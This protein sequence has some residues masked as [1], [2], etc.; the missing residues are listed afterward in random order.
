MAPS[1]ERD[2]GEKREK[3][4]REGGIRQLLAAVKLLINGLD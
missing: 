3:K 1:R 2:K 4:E